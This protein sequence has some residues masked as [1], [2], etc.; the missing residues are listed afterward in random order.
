MSDEELQQL[1]KGFTPKN[2]DTNTKWAVKNLTE[3]MKPEVS[4]VQMNLYRR[5]CCLVPMRASLGG[6]HKPKVTTVSVIVTLRGGGGC[7]RDAKERTS[8]GSSR[9]QF[10]PMLL[11]LRVCSFACEMVSVLF[12]SA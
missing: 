10:R 5:T 8:R 4:A 2:T 6:F 9:A 12:F 1:S 11:T 7:G 3:W